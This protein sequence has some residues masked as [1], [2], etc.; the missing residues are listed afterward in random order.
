ML[1]SDYKSL[2]APECFKP[3]E[4]TRSADLYLQNKVLT[5]KRMEKNKSGME[6]EAFYRNKSAERTVTRLQGSCERHA[7]GSLQPH[8]LTAAD[9]GRLCEIK[10]VSGFTPALD[11]S[12]QKHPS[13]IRLSGRPGNNI[14]CHLFNA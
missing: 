2:R 9:S 3:D 8:L 14:L 10:P 5:F 7:A 6:R 4:D 12:N 13:L 1:L 11:Q